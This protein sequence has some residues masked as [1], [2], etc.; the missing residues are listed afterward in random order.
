MAHACICSSGEADSK[1]IPG[2]GE[3][4]SILDS[5]EENRLK[6]S[7]VSVLLLRNGRT[8]SEVAHIYTSIWPHDHLH[9]G[10]HTYLNLREP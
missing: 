1:A 7:G 6:N 4:T 9:T 8:V 10:M 5:S 3:K 2:P